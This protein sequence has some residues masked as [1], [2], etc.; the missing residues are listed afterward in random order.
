MIKSKAN[1]GMKADLGNRLEA[2][3]ISIS[4]LTIVSTAKAA[5]LRMTSTALFRKEAEEVKSEESVEQQEDLAEF[6]P[7]ASTASG[8]T[9]E[10]MAIIIDQPYH[11]QHVIINLRNI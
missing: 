1:K 10:E 4:P 3:L 5:C 7:L 11:M 8:P 2:E 6:A 9:Q